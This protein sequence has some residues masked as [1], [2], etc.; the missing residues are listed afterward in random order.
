MG[1]LIVNPTGDAFIRDD[2]PTSNFGS[3]VNLRVAKLNIPAAIIRSVL[4]FDL[5]AIPVSATINS[6]VLTLTRDPDI[7]VS[8]PFDCFVRRVTTSWSEGQVTWDEAATGTPWGS[9]GGDFTTVDQ[10]TM[11][12]DNSAS[13]NSSDIAALVTTAYGIS[14]AEID[15]IV[16]KQNEAAANDALIESSEA[17]ISANRPVLTVVYTESVPNDPSPIFIGIARRGRSRRPLAASGGGNPYQ[18]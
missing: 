17:V 1:A 13:W 3:N 8:T 16:M 9:P 10:G 5:S 6:A 4:R 2:D 12:L 11:T 14:P 18:L 7:A 15:M